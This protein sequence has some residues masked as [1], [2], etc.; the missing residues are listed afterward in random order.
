MSDIHSLV[1]A[2]WLHN[3]HE[4]RTS[5]LYG[6]NAHFEQYSGFVFVELIFE[7]ENTVVYICLY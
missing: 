4:L 5:V 3:Y 6:G 1:F 2:F 7:L